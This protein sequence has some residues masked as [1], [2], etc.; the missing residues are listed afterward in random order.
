MEKFPSISVEFEHNYDVIFVV[1]FSIAVFEDIK[2]CA[3]LKG[4]SLCVGAFTLFGENL[5]V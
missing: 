3:L 5:N 1:F 4:V 2:M